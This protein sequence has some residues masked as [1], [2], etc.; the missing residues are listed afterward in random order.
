MPKRNKP[1]DVLN[2]ERGASRQ[3]KSSPDIPLIRALGCG[4]IAREFEVG[5]V[6][7]GKVK[8]IQE[9]S[10]MLQKRF[11]ALKLALIQSCFITFDFDDVLRKA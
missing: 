8:Q 11:K 9:A 3:Q 10:S 2:L 1:A 5:I 7:S 4:Y 6:A